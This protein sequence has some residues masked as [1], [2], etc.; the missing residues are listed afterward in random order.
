[1]LISNSYN[2]PRLELEVV[3][4]SVYRQVPPDLQMVAFIS[5]ICGRISH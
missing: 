1:M 3:Y 2:I 4:A 5:N